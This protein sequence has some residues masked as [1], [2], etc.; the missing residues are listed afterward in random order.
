MRTPHQNVDLHLHLE[1]SLPAEDAVALAQTADHPWSALSARALKRSFRY[2]SF[3]DFLATIRDMCRLL[4]SPDALRSASR[5]ISLALARQ[6]IAYAEIYVSP[7]VYMRWG[8]PWDELTGA[9]EEGFA[10]GEAESGATCAVLLDTVR[11][12][13]PSAGHEILNAWEKQP[14]K[15]AIGFGLGGAESHPLNEFADLFERA[16]SCGLRTLAHAG[17]AGGA[18]DVRVALES[19]RVDRIAHGIR[20]VD[21]P[22]LLRELADRG[23]PLDLAITSNYR[24]R[25]VTDAPH[26]LRAL[27]DAGV[28]VSLGTDDPSLFRTQLSKELRVARRAASLSP[29]ELLFLARN[30]IDHSFATTELKLRLHQLRDAADQASP[31]R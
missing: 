1:G 23:V 2:R 8:I 28:R 17:E 29:A 25:V 6:E 24:T 15:R 14:W 4:A 9:C 5:S 21:D 7:Y 19:L 20:A 16:R 31:S 12:W 10:D 18:S 30:A 11:Q 13:S 22:S 27:L 26:P 3:D